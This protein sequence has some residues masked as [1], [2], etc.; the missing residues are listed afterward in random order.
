MEQNE[1][2]IDEAAAKEET[3]KGKSGRKKEYGRL[4]FFA[5]SSGFCGGDVDFAQGYQD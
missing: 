1:K 4:E 5:G 2:N 3:R